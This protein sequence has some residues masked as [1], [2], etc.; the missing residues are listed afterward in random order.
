MG[1]PGG[2]IYSSERNEVSA[3]PRSSTRLSLDWPARRLGA[4][5]DHAA[6]TDDLF[7]HGTRLRRAC[8]LLDARI[9][10]RLGRIFFR[11]NRPTC[12][13]ERARA[14]AP[15]R[16]A[17]PDFG[18]APGLFEAKVPFDPRLVDAARR[19]PNCTIASGSRRLPTL[20]RRATART[21]RHEAAG[22]RTSDEA[23]VQR[24]VRPV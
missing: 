6:T 13:R 7:F 4:L 1:G 5:V 22:E 23:P 9:S 17:S 16:W 20:G 15:R 24:L 12:G 21:T 8:S 10:M 2:A 11:K 14:S 3:G 19:A 18:P